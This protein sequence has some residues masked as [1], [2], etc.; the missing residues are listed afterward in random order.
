LTVADVL[1]LPEVRRGVPEVVA[2]GG[3]L[4][5]RVRWVHAGEAPYIGA[6]LKGGEL[7][8]TGG[9]NIGR[10]PRD[11][12]HLVEGLAE[13]GAAGLV[14][15]LGGRFE[16]VP[17]ALAGCA[18]QHG[19]PVIVLHRSA[20]FIAITERANR[21]IVD[22]Q[23]ALARDVAA[24]QARAT[25]LLIEGAGVADLLALLVARIENPAAL[26]M[27]SGGIAFQRT[28]RAGDQEVSAA[29]G[30]VARRLPAA[31]D[32]ETYTI[33][34]EQ[35]GEWGRLVAIA[36]DSPL[37]E[38]DRAAVRAIGEL[39]AVELL[40]GREPTAFAE[41]RRGD[42][43]ADL[44]DG[45]L[46]PAAAAARAAAV[47]FE[48]PVDVVVPVAVAPGADL[49]RP[50]PTPLREPPWDLVWR[51]AQL[52][53][54]GEGAQVL[55]SHQRHGERVLMLIGLQRAGQREAMAER[56][57]GLIADGARRRLPEAP[58]PVVCV[59]AGVHSWD[60]LREGLAKTIEAAVPATLQP[61][62][63]WH[64]ITLPSV[65]RLVW[66]LRDRDELEAFARARLRPVVEHDRLRKTKMLD[67]L[68]AF[69][70]NAGRKADAARELFIERQSLYPRLARIER[71]LD[72]DLSDPD[73]LCGLHLALRIFEMLELE[74]G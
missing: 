54:K 64:D 61:P 40:R 60:A 71:L 17:T 27:A 8:L 10:K 63:P 11:E 34:S 26:E 6:L 67:T 35:R 46:D 43:L 58:A 51:D 69:C 24:L 72:A 19:L 47:G 50:T 14:I 70:H 33:A 29:C 12:E 20:P 18:E 38:A 56:L 13:R 15:E 16:E 9:H 28:H 66:S 73:V 62:R 74:A 42:F 45:K 59:G 39:V 68:R 5:S 30:L 41:Q 65:D 37:D 31:P 57:G 2:G 49:G 21:E 48:Q 32:C 3:R 52:A 44:L 23:G 7:L 25:E 36:V 53:L 1:E 4:G 22:S 55:V